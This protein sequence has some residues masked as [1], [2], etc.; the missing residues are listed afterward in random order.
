MLSTVPQ[1]ADS[2]STMRFP[3]QSHIN[4][5]RDALWQRSGNGASIMVGSGLSRSADR[6]IRNAKEMPTWRDLVSHLHDTLYPQGS[7]SQGGANHRPATDNVRIAQEYEAAFG[8]SAL[9]DALRRLVPDTEYTPSL[10]HQRLLKLPWRDIYTTN[11]DTL[12]ERAQGQVTEQQYSTVTSVEE[13]PMA[14]QP[15]IV[16]LHGSLPSQF[17]LI[18]TEEDYRTYPAKFAPFVNTVQQSMMETVFLLIGFSGDDPNF[19]NWSGWVRDNLGPSAP[20]IY[21]AG[22]LRLSPHRRRMLENHSVVP[23]DLAQHPRAGEWP[24]NLQDE[25]ATKWLLHTLELGRPYD[26]TSWPTASN[27]QSNGICMVLQPIETATTGE[28]RKERTP[29]SSE[30]ESSPEEAREITAIWRH[31][32]LIYPGWLTMPPF[33][34]RRMERDTDTWGRTILASLPAMNPV[35][36]LRA[37][38]ELVW[39]EEVLL[40]PMHPCLQS[41]IKNTLDAIDC[42]NRTITGAAAPNKDWTAIR[43]DWRNVALA[44][45]TAARFRFDGEAFEKAVEAVEPFKGEDPDLRHRVLHEKCLMAIYDR[46][47]NSLEDSLVNWNTGNCDPAWMMRKSAV[48]WEA[49]RNSEAREL[50]NDSLTAI[51]AMPPDERGLASLSRESWATFVALDFNNRLTLLDRLRELVPMRCDPFDERR[52]VTEEMQQ[53]KAE[54]D[55][56]PFDINRR[57]GTSERWVNYNPLTKA[58]RAVRLSDMAGLPPR[59]GHSSVWAEV[60]KKAAEE[61]ADHDPELAVRLVLR[62]CDGD[63]DKT[64]GRVLTRTRVATMPTE[65]AEALTACCLNALE[66]A[67]RDKVTQASATQQRFNT[68]AE[69]L[70]RLVIRLEPDQVEQILNKAVEYCQSAELAKSF[71]DGTIRNLLIRSWEALPNERRQHRA[72]NLLGAEIVGLNKI[73]PIVEHSW[74]DPGEVVTQ[75][76]MPRTTENEPQWQATI[77]LVVRGLTSNPTARH[78]AAVRMIPLVD[79]DQLTEDESLRIAT[80]LWSEQHTPPDGLPRNT[81]LSDWEFLTFP[82][83]TPGI[84]VQRFR[85]KWLSHDANEP[86]EIQRRNRGF[87][88]YGNSHNGLNHDHLDVESRLWQVGAAM[89]SLQ[90]NGQN[91]TLSQ[92]DSDHLTKLLESW[93]DDPAP[94][95]S[96]FR[97]DGMLTTLTQQLTLNM[98]KALPS[99]MSEITISQFLGNKIHTKMQ[100]LTANRLP[101]FDLATALVKINP[102]RVA[103]IATALRV[104]VTSDDSQLTENAFSGMYRWLETASEPDSQVPQPPDD[105]VREIGIGIASRRNTAVAAALQVATWIFKNGQDSHKEAIQKLA[106]DGLRYLAQ[107]L[108]YDREHEDPDEVPRKRLYCAKLT[109]AM[110]KSGLD[111]SPAVAA[112]LDIAR[113]DPLPELRQAVETSGME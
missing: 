26:I 38:R 95:Q 112:W 78:R 54:E 79:S 89:R 100:E 36:R 10:E 52:Y 103:E 102:E 58:Y 69:V 57:R 25:Y 62:A 66:K 30:P 93:A 96:T 16:K 92:V 59:T 31:N 17:P 50:L 46:D 12:L 106:E 108:Q 8:R 82:E 1:P 84:A 98:A 45:V 53:D 68:A 55:P 83:P 9:H 28:P 99:L 111:K 77:D 27:R 60:L 37:L 109:A 87:Q 49:D 6:I 90:E 29:S 67:M 35:E 34:H 47:F 20:K 23:I 51:K 73:E 2:S 75:T 43:E 18:V 72:L 44:L 86:Y 5:V 22:W 3:D 24:D 105:L 4:R 65:I 32:R 33:N 48:L 56:P 14:S 15:R 41:A 81:T 39:R 94:E 80:A 42:Q 7:P 13:I 88:I 64:L 107:E 85:T 11:W 70:S 19:L 113:E 76:E 21:L 91:L 74:P 101:A 40:I 110:A 71:V 61:V 63:N 97:R 104:G